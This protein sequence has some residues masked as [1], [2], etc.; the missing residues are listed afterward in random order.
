MVFVRQRF[1]FDGMLCRSCAEATYRTIQTRNLSWGWFGT[2]SFFATI[3]YAIGN[4][5]NYRRGRQGLADPVASASVDEAKL[6]VRPIWQSMLLRLP[7]VLVIFAVI[8][9]A[10]WAIDR[11]DGGH[12]SSDPFLD[13]YLTQFDVAFATR[14]NMVKTANERMAAYTAGFPR[15]IRSSD[16]V[17]TE[18]ADVEKQIAKIPTP[19][20]DPL[21]SL[22]NAWRASVSQARA[23]EEALGREDTTQHRADDAAAFANEN[24]ALKAL[25]GYL[26]KQVGP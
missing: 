19:A 16:L 24:D 1:G 9:A 4:V 22:D 6:R 11:G 15:S 8:G 5:R 14:Q 18:L 26:D 25:A 2:I 21:R 20:S 12:A 17:A 10:I 23:A 3:A 7:I 13:S